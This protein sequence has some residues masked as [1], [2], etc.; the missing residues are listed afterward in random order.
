[1]NAVKEMPAT[2]LLTVEDG[3][4]LAPFELANLSSSEFSSSASYDFRP[5]P[6]LGFSSS[7][8]L[9]MGVVVTDCIRVSEAPRLPV[10]YEAKT[11]TSVTLSGRINRDQRIEVGPNQRIRLTESA[12][13]DSHGGVVVLL[14][15]T[16][17]RLS[18]KFLLDGRT[19]QFDEFPAIAPKGS[20]LSPAPFLELVHGGLKTKEAK[21]A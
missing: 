15:D 9:P 17:V 21:A 20:E 14:D 6:I 8:E 11:T 5:A 19:V 12:M 1:M 10:D 16:N 13:V 2:D 18:G 4:R 7:G 3:S